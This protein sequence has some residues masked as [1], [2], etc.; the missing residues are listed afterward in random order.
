LTD[1][2]HHTHTAQTGGAIYNT[3]EQKVAANTT[4]LCRCRNGVHLSTQI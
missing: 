2:Q 4:R 1:S 3:A